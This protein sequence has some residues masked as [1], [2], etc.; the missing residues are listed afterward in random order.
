MGGKVHCTLGTPPSPAP[1]SASGASGA[2]AASAAGG[3]EPAANG[4]PG[5]RLGIGPS[6]LCGGRT[7]LTIWIP[8]AD[9][10][11]GAVFVDVD[12]S[13]CKFPAL[14]TPAYVSD[15]AARRGDWR[16]TGTHSIVSASSAGFRLVL[17]SAELNS[18]ALHATATRDRWEV[19]WVGDAGANAGT[20]APGN[21]GTVG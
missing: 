2:S 19:S 8:H 10:E 5:V 9:A 3:S 16:A 7:G 14:R 21:T 12:T 6:R 18:T 4:K 13:H 15:V 11:A 17:L 1:H 20:T